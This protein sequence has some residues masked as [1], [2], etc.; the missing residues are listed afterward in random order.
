MTLATKLRALAAMAEEGRTADVYSGLKYLLKE[1]E[2]PDW[3]K[4]VC[5]DIDGP[6]DR[7]VNLQETA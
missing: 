2:L 7:P 3:L 1:R 4:R 6:R 5:E